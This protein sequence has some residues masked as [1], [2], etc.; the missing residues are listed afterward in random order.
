[1]R[2][3]VSY[4][5][6]AAVG[7]VTIVIVGIFAYQILNTQQRLLIAEVERSAHQLSETVK[8]STRYDMLLNQRES[9]YRI[10]NTISHQSGI[11]KVRIFNKEGRI[12]TS[13]DPGDVGK[14]VDKNA[15]ACY[16]CH[17]AGRTLEKL[18]ISETTRIFGTP[19]QGR[20]LG[21]INPIYN[22]PSCWQSECHAHPPDQKVLGV[23]DITMSLAEVDRSRR[24]SQK[25]VPIFAA[26]AIAALSLVIYLLV[27]VIVLR[28]INQIAV[29]TRHVAGGDL[30]YTVTLKKRDEIGDLG[31]SFNAMTR[32]LSEAQRQLHQQDK[33][34]S[35]GRLAAGVAH[36]INNPLTGVLTYSSYLL[37]RAGDRPEIKEDLEVI[38]RETKRCREIVKGLLDFA[39]QSAPEKRPRDINDI[40]VKATRILQ[41][42]FSLNHVELL[43]ELQ[44]QLPLVSADSS[45]MQ[46]VLV[47]LFMNASDAMGEK[48]GRITVSTSRMNEKYVRDG[49]PVTKEY[50]QIEVGDTG[51]GIPPENL[52]KIFE[53]FFTT[54]GQKGNG[55]GL[56][57]VWGIIEKHDGHISARSE[58][59]KGTTFTILLPVDQNKGGVERDPGQ[60]GKLSSPSTGSTQG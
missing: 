42:Q 41:N 58:V 14:M 20:T 53:P 12:I 29:A 39:R 13:S 52:T 3:K 23:L 8:S 28:P 10:I 50:V 36:E 46:Q 48:G 60:S 57:M 38:V 24:A 18:P 7:G 31:N 21:I 35:V 26:I 51:C 55:L 56:A 4:K 40:V 5:I 22:E 30:D 47:N 16:A 34:A 11:E 49:L 44:P 32:Q 33:L 27:D 2:F 6:I 25:R 59:G 9:V 1:M 43:Q 45:Q 15:E 54:K 17:T 37:K 19:V